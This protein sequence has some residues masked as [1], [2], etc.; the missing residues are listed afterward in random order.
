MSDVKSTGPSR[1]GV[2]LGAAGAAASLIVPARAFAQDD[3]PPADLVAA[4][5][6]EGSVVFYTAVDLAVSLKLANT[7][8]Q[9]YPQI[10][11]QVERTG[12][13]RLT[14]RVMQE[15]DAKIKAV[16][17]VDSSDSSGLLDWKDR[18]WLAK[19]LPANVLKMWP[20]D[21]QDADQRFATF[22][23]HVSV[24]GYN[25]KQVRPENAPKSFAD[26]LDP[27][28]RG[29]IVKAHPA[30][31]GSVLVSTFSVVKVL[32]WQYFEQLAKQRVM[33]V[34]A[35][36]DAVKK[37]AQGERS[38]MVDGSEYSALFTKEAGNPIEVIYPTEGSPLV[39]AMVSVMEE[40]PHPNAA[41]LFTTFLFSRDAQQLIS[42]E[43]ALRSFHPGVKAK[44]GRKPLAEIK[45]LYVDP[46]ELRKQSEEI[47]AR[48]SKIFGV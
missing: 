36:V 5:N 16:D 32:G 12:A 15:Y 41:R 43:F 31:A 1:R 7:F 10:H 39:P 46:Q 4:A 45:L 2:V 23:A 9:R 33:Q 20:K 40:A 24:M 17:V 38:I 14:Q 48:Y 29:R 19:F 3:A 22:R 30:F 11:V 6:R 8:M 47:K 18:G 21:E 25:T 13:E 37:L 35:A 26:L 27:K 44:E 42:D 34:Q 28:W